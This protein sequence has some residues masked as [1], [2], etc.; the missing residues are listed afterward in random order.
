MATAQEL[1]EELKAEVG[2]REKGWC[3]QGEEVG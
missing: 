2:E 1:A 3:H